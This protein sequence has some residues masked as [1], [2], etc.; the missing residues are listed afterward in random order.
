M[1]LSSF[2]LQSKGNDSG[3]GRMGEEGSQLEGILP[4]EGL[5][6]AGSW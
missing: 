1:G 2:E 6:M 3:K 5:Q 4:Q